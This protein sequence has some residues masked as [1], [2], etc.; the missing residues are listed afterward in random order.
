MAQ[1]GLKALHTGA[2]RI[3]DK[4]FEKIPVVGPRY[5]KE[6]E[7]HDRRRRERR[8]RHR[9]DD[10]DR[11]PRDNR[12]SESESEDSENSYRD[13]RSQGSRRSHRRSGRR[14]DRS[15]RSDRRGDLNRGYDSDH[16]PNQYSAPYFP[17]PPLIAVD[18]PQQSRGMPQ[19]SGQQSP[20]VPSPYS[21]A[22][23]GANPGARDDYFAGH[24]Q[25][26]M[27]Y[28]PPPPHS[29]GP[30]SSAGGLDPNQS[31]SVADR[32]R[33]SNYNRNDSSRSQDRGSPAPGY[34]NALTLRHPSTDY[35]GYSP[36]EFSPENSDDEYSR[37]DRKHRSK[38]RGSQ[39]SRSRMS[40][41][42]A[43]AKEGFDKHKK[44][45]GAAGLGV[46]AGGIIGNMIASKGSHGRKKS[47][48]N[49]AGALIGA[50]I[51][52]IGAA[53]LEHRH[54]QSKKKK[55]EASYDGYDSF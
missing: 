43:R 22:N 41:M 12:S 50:A 23:Y 37:R 47:K 15:D 16:G 7:E 17:P 9:Y 18:E 19:G 5:F 53:A 55:Q 30:P 48:T 6:K 36:P 21:P 8:N 4:A 29:Q 11:S 10:G 3:P 46:V 34:P 49:L 27:P 25:D 54:E 14:D 39:R 38:S 24:P 28:V 45:V 13:Q 20:Y 31:S 42:S 1:L 26:H 33:P 51:G 40:T 44:D 35:R 2:E 32:Y 52:G